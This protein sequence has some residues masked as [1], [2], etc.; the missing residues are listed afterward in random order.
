MGG[1][2]HRAW[3]GWR[4]TH[5]GPGGGGGRRGRGSAGEEALNGAHE[6]AQR[7]ASVVGRSGPRRSVRRS[8]RCR[9][10][11]WPCRMMQKPLM[12]LSHIVMGRRRDGGRACR[13]YDWGEPRQAVEV[14]RERQSSRA[15]RINRGGQGERTR[16][17]VNGCE[18]GRV[19]GTGS[20]RGMQSMRAGGGRARRQWVGCKAGQE[21]RSRGAGQAVA[22]NR[23]EPG[24]RSRR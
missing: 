8:H 24:G 5:H 14:R 6:G 13:V 18:A 3:E 9:S 21:R 1:S 10:H 16:Q 20:S 19:R 12:A 22:C 17:A 15:G 23:C 7:R 11:A 4:G 2:T